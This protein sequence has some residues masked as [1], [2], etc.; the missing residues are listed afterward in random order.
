MVSHEARQ[1]GSSRRGRHAIRRARPCAETAR[2][3][4]ARTTLPRGVH[5]T[6]VSEMRAPR[7]RGKI[8]LS[9][10]SRRHPFRPLERIMALTLFPFTG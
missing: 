6:R 8:R 9:G 10:A 4:H 5:R 7:V 1:L 3:R 2:L